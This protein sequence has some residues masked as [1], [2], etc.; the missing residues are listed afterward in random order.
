MKA[1]D[2]ETKPISSK[3]RQK[4]NDYEEFCDKA[5]VKPAIN[6]L[7]Y[8]GGT[9][10]ITKT[11]AWKEL[12]KTDTDAKEYRIID[13]GGISNRIEQKNTLKNALSV[14]PSKAK[15]KLKD[16]TFC[17]NNDKGSGYSRKD[18]TIYISSKATK[19]EIIHEVG[20][21]LEFDLFD[22]AKVIQL[23]N[24]LVQGLTK[25]DI[26]I[27]TAIDSAGN[28]TNIFTLKSD[29]FIN[30][31]QSRMYVD[32]IKDALNADGTINID[33]MGEVISVAIE[34]YFSYPKAMQKHF[35]EMYDFIEKELYG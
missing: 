35:R 7:R 15:E 2:M 25:D 31:Y 27:R 17:L 23:K 5:R 4:I 16:V 13:S 24:R 29:K 14:F 3:I 21:H 32:N 9:S 6:R 8:E 11:K 18:K 19:R 10:D 20:H 28:K 22:S 26:I 34:Y 12:K 1:L 33:V 30:G